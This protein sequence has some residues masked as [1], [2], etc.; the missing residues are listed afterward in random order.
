LD[1]GHIQRRPE[2]VGD[3]QHKLDSVGAFDANFAMTARCFQNCRR[4]VP[5]VVLK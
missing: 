2:C 4:R 1:T 3:P 5:Q